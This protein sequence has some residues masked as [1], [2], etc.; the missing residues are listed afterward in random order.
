M[1]SFAVTFVLDIVRYR[2]YLLTSMELI[3]TAACC[4]FDD[5]KILADTINKLK[6]YYMYQLE[7]HF[8]W[9]QSLF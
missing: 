4:N 2:F 3:L 6:L 1:D 9:W 5:E 7:E 8:I